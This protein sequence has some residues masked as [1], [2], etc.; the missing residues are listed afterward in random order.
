[1]RCEVAA[2][3]ATNGERLTDATNE[4]RL[5]GGGSEADAGVVEGGSSTRVQP[6]VVQAPI[7]TAN[8]RTREAYNAYQ[9][10][11]MRKRRAG[12]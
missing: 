3:V 7:R 11:Y 5:E 10:D 9:R 4:N 12:V 8:R 1:V 6:F 2:R